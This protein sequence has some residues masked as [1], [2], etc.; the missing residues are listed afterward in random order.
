MKLFDRRLAAAYRKLAATP[1][2]QR[3]FG[4]L[5]GFGRVFAEVFVPGAPDQTNFNLGARRAALRII[6][7]A[8]MTEER[9]RQLAEL[10]QQQEKH[11]GRAIID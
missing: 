11:D 9:A 1:E 8:G 3:V 4:D 2:G 5:I 6:S 10:A 7:M